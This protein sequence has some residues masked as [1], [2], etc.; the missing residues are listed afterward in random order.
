MTSLHLEN[1]KSMYNNYLTQYKQF[2][3]D[4]ITNLQSNNHKF[5]QIKGKIFDSAEPILST[6]TTQ[7]VDECI[8]LCSNNEKCS[9]ANYISNS[10]M[11]KSGNGTLIDSSNQDNYAIIS[12]NF[13][14]LLKVQEINEKLTTINLKIQKEIKKL[15]PK[16]LE[17]QTEVKKQNEDLTKTYDKL[18]EERKTID[19]NIREFKNLERIEIESQ[20]KTNQIYYIYLLLFCGVILLVG[21]F[22]YKCKRDI[23]DSI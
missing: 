9:G 22:I 12:E 10:C 14:L 6:Q 11:L 8:A 16:L 20:L 1:L 4:Y 17:E 5:I 19:K 23:D 13:G 3:T 7:T 21:F 15:K 18:L 2:F